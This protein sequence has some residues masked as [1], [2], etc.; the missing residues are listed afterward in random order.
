LWRIRDSYEVE[1]PFSWVFALLALIF[2]F[3]GLD[4]FNPSKLVSPILVGVVIGFVA[5]ELAHRGVARM[6]GM[7]AHFV[8]FIP[9]L[10]LTFLSGFLPVKIIAPGYVR[11][12]P[13]YGFWHYRG[14]LYSVAAGPLTNI[15]ISI[16]SLATISLVGY[17]AFLEP[18]AFVN[19]WLAF[20]NLLPI[21][22]LDGSK[23]FAL[24]KILWLALI[25][26][27]I[28]LLMITGF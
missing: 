5:H 17:R 13:L 12:V 23:V 9:G 10:L 19:A 4:V 8:A 22:P 25:A 1:E 24:N 11:A 6:Y 18:V 2:A 3:K 14:F 15:I 28:V 27:S 20:F 7:S 16:A 21:P 26:S